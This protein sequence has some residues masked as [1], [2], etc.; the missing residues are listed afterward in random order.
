MLFETKNL[1]VFIYKD[2]IDMR[3]GFEKLYYFTKEIM[4]QD[5]NQGHVYLFFGK[6][7]RRL[8]GLFFDGTGLVQ[9]SKRIERGKFMSRLELGEISEITLLEF[10]QV[11]N[12]GL[13]V[14]PK[15]ERSFYTNRSI[16]QVGPSLQA[17]FNQSNLNHAH[18]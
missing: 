11:F 3:C 17:G 5:I 12:G 10:K 2:M 9:I 8:K 15:V 7:R 16:T 6:N 1:R 18:P 13:I 4:K 14:R